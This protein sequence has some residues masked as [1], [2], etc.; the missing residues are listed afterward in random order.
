M[1]LQ[2]RLIL[3]IGMLL[4]ATIV[5]L[6]LSFERMLVAV[7][8]QNTGAAAL[9]IA[10]TVA[11]LEVI[12]SG[13][14]ADDPSEVI[15]P[16]AERIR[17]ATGAEFIVVGNRNEI[18]YS[19]PIEERI[20]L[21]MVGDDNESVLQG[22]EIISEAIGSLGSSVR[23]KAPVFDQTGQVIGIVSVGFMIE[24]LQQE[25]AAYRTD[26]L[27][28]AIFTLLSGCIGA[29]WIARRV[30]RSIFGLEPREIGMLYQ[31]KEAILE[32][33]HEGI[34]AVNGQGR[35]TLVNQTAMKLLGRQEGEVI[36]GMPLLELLPESRL[37]EVLRTGRA[38]F[39]QE[40]LIN[41]NAVVANRLPIRDHG[42]QVIGAVSSFRN[43]S[44]LLRVMEELTQ[45]KRYAEALRTQ[46]HEYSNKLYAIYGLIQLESYQ[47]AM[48]LIT[49]ETDVHQGLIHFLM[50][51]IPDPMIGGILIGKF[52]RA[53]ELK[54]GLTVDEL[55]SFKKISEEMNRNQLV[56]IIGNLID[57]ALEAVLDVEES[58]RQVHVLLTDRND[59]L[60]VQ[61]ADFGV[62]IPQEVAADIF[63]AGY[64]TKAAH[65]RGLGLA[66]VR[67][68]VTELGGSIQFQSAPGKGTVFQV[69][70]PIDERK[71]RSL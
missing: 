70:I 20:G 33:V 61:V 27:L 16:V 63:Q 38:E 19:H 56:T 40:T 71:G 67:Q 12:R 32:T 51:E 36:I 8:E 54:V 41:G 50:R 69:H 7:Q 57:N 31:E 34:I 28:T 46:T 22:R 3:L 39:D 2:T 60:L 58:C 64:S 17:T 26:I 44:E 47:E 37:M 24:K 59:S 62:G 1:R 48:D 21:R 23:G 65:G 43:K 49:Y 14:T 6:T 35:I 13:F 52:N 45:V 11:S 42:R 15:Q 29:V 5:V 68:A 66:I 10:K 25:A 4:L 55:S 18:R 9:K 53:N 30:K